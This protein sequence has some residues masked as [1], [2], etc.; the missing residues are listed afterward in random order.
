M[1]CYCFGVVLA[2]AELVQVCQWSVE[3][4]ELFCSAALD[5]EL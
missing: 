5:P 2:A 4:S 3:M 1:T